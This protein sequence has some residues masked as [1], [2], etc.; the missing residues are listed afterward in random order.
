MILNYST[1]PV[2]R[3]VAN[4][5]AAVG[6]TPVAL[7]SIPATNVVRVI[8]RIVFDTNLTRTLDMTANGIAQWNFV[9]E[10]VGWTLYVGNPNE[11]ASQAAFG[12]KGDSGPVEFQQPI[13]VPAGSIVWIAWGDVL[14]GSTGKCVATVHF[15]SVM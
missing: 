12:L 8:H 2:F 4:V 9:N 3:M 13:Q 7:G 5:S 1:F 11:R 10:T 15:G 14:P 6:S